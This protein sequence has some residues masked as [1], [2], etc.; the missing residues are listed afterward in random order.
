MRCQNLLLILEIP[1]MVARKTHLLEHALNSGLA[2]ALAA[3][4]I[5]AI[6]NAANALSNGYS[7]DDNAVFNAAGIDNDFLSNWFN[8]LNSEGQAALEKRQNES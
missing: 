3:E 7:A 1:L 4:V 8:P 5:E 6:K 2:T